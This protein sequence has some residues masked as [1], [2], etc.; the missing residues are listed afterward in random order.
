M[1]LTIPT[2]G[3]S[4]HRVLNK[5]DLQN[6]TPQARDKLILALSDLQKAIEDLMSAIKGVT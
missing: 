5:S 1:T 3:T 6:I 4:I 2:W